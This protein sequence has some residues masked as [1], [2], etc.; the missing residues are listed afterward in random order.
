MAGIDETLDFVAINI[1]IL[2]VSDSRT[3]ADDKSGDIL[4]ERLV[5]SGHNLAARTIVTDDRIEILVAW[6]IGTAASVGLSN[7]SGTMNKG[8]VKSSP[9]RLVGLFIAQV[10]FAK[11]AGG[12]ADRFQDLW[13]NGRI[14]RHSFSL[15]NR[16]CHTIAHRMTPGH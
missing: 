9:V 12:V 13:Q 4:V 5:A 10:P 8:F 15:E 11:D 3:P 6:H 7:P 2:T 16:V 14:E 1:A